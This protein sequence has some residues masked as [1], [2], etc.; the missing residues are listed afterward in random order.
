[1]ASMAAVNWV[2]LAEDAAQVGDIVSADA[3]GMPLYR[4]V[5]L[6]DGRA[7]L[8]DEH[9]PAIQIVPLGALRWKAAPVRS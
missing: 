9:C 6:A 7:W 3:G 1:M 8:R 5:A 2:L 4:I